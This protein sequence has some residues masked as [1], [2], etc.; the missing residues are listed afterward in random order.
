MEG[1]LEPFLYP[2][3]RLAAA[4]ANTVLWLDATDPILVLLMLKAQQHHLQ[5]ARQ[6]HWWA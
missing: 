5:N 2:A 4:A 1:R 3:A 6:S